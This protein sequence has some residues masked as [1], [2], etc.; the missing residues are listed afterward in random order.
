MSNTEQTLIMVKVYGGQCGL[1]GKISGRFERRGKPFFKG[2]T[3]FMSSGHVVA[4]VFEGRD[5]VKQG[6]AMFGIVMGQNI[7]HVSDSVETAKKEIGL[8]FPGSVIQY[9]LTSESNI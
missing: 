3:R 4:I 5:V 7:C 6:R 2:L 1:A 8:W 9:G